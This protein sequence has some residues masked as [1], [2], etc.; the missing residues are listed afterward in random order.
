MTTHNDLSEPQG[1]VTHYREIATQFEHLGLCVVSFGPD[2]CGRKQA[3]GFDH[4]YLPTII[5]RRGISQLIYEFILFFTLFWQCLCRRPDVIYSRQSYITVSSPVVAWLFSIR[6]VTEV[7]GLQVED[8]EGRDS[9]W[10][11]KAINR[12][13]EKLAYELSHRII[14]VSARICDILSE[15][16]HIRRYRFLALPNGVNVDRFTN[17]P[18]DTRHRVREELNIAR[19]KFCVMYVGGYVTFDG[20]ELLPEVAQRLPEN[21]RD[22]IVFVLIGD[23]ETRSALKREIEQREVSSQFRVLGRRD[24]EEIPRY[25]A[26]ADVGI[27][28]YRRCGSDGKK[29]D[30]GRTS[31]KCLEYC[32][33]GVPVLTTGMAHTEYVTQHDAG[34]VVEPDNPEALADALERIAQLDQAELREKGRAGRDYVRRHRSW[35][36]V[37]R[38]TVKEFPEPT[39]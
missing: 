20:V 25:L 4:R 1:P 13:C 27:A 38:R 32:A 9:S 31:L 26:A 2:L 18:P 10:V 11:K 33:A 17:L 24:H 7:N 35:K 37:A 22:K 34:W 15:R 23:G 19:D 28:P 36:S 6:L 16:Y 14:G 30:L 21:T 29:K 8:L 3:M 39:T 12:G 5:H